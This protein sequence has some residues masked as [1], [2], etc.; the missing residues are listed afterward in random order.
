MSKTE[1]A[2]QKKSCEIGGVEQPLISRRFLHL[3]SNFRYR[4]IGYLPKYHWVV[5]SK[6]QSTHNLFSQPLQFCSQDL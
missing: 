6:R 5:V 4:Y 1:G 2:R 3:S